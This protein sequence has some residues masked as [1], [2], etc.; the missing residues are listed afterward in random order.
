MM[1]SSNLYVSRYIKLNGVDLRYLDWGSEGKPQGGTGQRKRLREHALSPGC[2]RMS[3]AHCS[4]QRMTTP[5]PFDD[6]PV[7]SA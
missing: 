5:R 3:D 1:A 4:V 6:D 2:E 7:T